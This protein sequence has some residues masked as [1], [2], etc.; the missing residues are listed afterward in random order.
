M[1]LKTILM[2]FYLLM[3]AFCFPILCHSQAE[4]INYSDDTTT[5]KGRLGTV[6]ET[7]VNAIN[8]NDADKI[9][10]FIENSF[11]EEFQNIAP[12]KAHQDIFLNYYRQTG[13]V[14][15][16][17][18]RTYVPE[19][20]LE[21]VLILKDVNYDSWQKITFSFVNEKDFTMKGIGISP[22]EIPSDILESKISLAELVEE[23]KRT[24]DRLAKQDLFSD[25]Y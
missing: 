7:I 9:R 19:N 6:T 12:M 17:S 16:H 23:T 20:P 3:L 8:S 10:A 21:N 2:K 14:S 1:N 4:K 24:L 13:G 18:I 5:P 15:F 25:L 22:A 11:A